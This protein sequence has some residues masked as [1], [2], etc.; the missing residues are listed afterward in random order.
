MR[1]ISCMRHHTGKLDMNSFTSGQHDCQT[2]LLTSFQLMFLIGL[3]G[4]MQSKTKAFLLM[5]TTMYV[6]GLDSEPCLAHAGNRC[7]VLP[8]SFCHLSMLLDWRVA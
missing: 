8:M 5:C 1:M 4:C 6:P 2:F 3:S 7:N